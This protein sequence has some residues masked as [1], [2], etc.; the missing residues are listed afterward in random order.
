VRSRAVADHVQTDLF[1]VEKLIFK[2]KWVQK[3]VKA[4]FNQTNEEFCV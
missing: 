3:K 4:R 2:K 1:S